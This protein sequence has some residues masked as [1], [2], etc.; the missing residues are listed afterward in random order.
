MIKPLIYAE[1]L[2]KQGPKRSIDMKLEEWER[3]KKKEKERM[4]EK[5]K[6]RKRE[7]KSKIVKVN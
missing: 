1:I 5:E 2:T 6:E 3:E 7:R 4:R